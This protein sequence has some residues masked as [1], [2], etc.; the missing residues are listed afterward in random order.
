MSGMLGGIGGAVV[1]NILYD[2]F[3]RPHEARMA[4]PTHDAGA[5]GGIGGI[6]PPGQSG[7]GI[8]PPHETYDPNAGV[9]GDWGGGNESNPAEAN[10]GVGGDGIPPLLRRRLRRR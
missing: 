10:A 5:G 2:Q 8:E 3:G 9:G 4:A 6:T 1:G 7:G